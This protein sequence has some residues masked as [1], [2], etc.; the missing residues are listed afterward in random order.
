MDNFSSFLRAL[1]PG[2]ILAMLGVT[3]GLIG[4]FFFMIMQLSQPQMNLLYSNLELEESATVM[5]RLDALNV[6]Y[7]LQNDGRS[8]Y[9]PSDRVSTLRVSLAGEGLGGSIT[10]YEI[11]D[12]GDTLGTTSFVQNINRV[13]AIEGELA[14]TIKGINAVNSAR[15][16]IVMPERQLFQR[17]ERSPTASIVLRTNS[18]GLA[19]SQV[20]AI[21]YLVAAAVPGLDPGS[22]SIIDQTGALLARGGQKNAEADYATDL[23]ERRLAHENRLRTQIEDL[24]GNTV[25][26]GRVRA[27]V[28]VQMNHQRI[29]TSSESYDPDGQV[30]RSS[31]TVEEITN[32]QESTPGGEVTVGNNL[33]DAQA[34][35]AS[36]ARPATSSTERTEATTNFEISKTMTTRITEAGEIEK[37]NVA[38]LVDGTYTED[39]EGVSTYQ[40]R[41]EAELDQLEALVRS[42]IGFDPNRGDTIEMVNLRFIE[43]QEAPPAIEPFN[44]LGLSKDDLFRILTTFVWGVVGILVL[45]LIVKPLIRRLIDSI[46]QPAPGQAQI[47]GQPAGQ[48]AIAGPT[49]EIPAELA[50][51][52]PQAIA[53]AS[54]QQGFVLDQDR[55]GIE[56]Q[57]DVASVEGKVQDSA[58]KKVGDIVT[59][60]PEES[61]AIVR[62]WL[63]SD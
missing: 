46:P 48:A 18:G 24:L 3:A 51:M 11:F 17:E 16:H 49:G 26:M 10:G 56:S 29:T 32:S 12:R 38:V 33:P 50:G 19:Q 58:L 8:I 47:A 2:R 13:R 21:R 45:L 54:A 37:I 14:R 23:V 42:T 61:A 4:F 39:A 35:A 55:A 36:S 34:T 25:G 62:G 31:N 43:L 41:P 57:I 63:Y 59:K 28:A 6:P 53:A 60:H 27:E 7:Q 1:G 5:Q 20:R 22:I 15:V 44:L 40:P 30:V 9:V 52:D